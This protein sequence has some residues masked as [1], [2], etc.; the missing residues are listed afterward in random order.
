MMEGLEDEPNNG[1]R[2]FSHPEILAHI[3]LISTLQE[4]II[5]AQKHD[6]RIFHIKAKLQEGKANCFWLDDDGVLLFRDRLGVPKD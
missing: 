3:T 6:A 2:R 5:E 1:D 4:Q